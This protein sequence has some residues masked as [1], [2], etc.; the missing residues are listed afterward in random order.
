MTKFNHVKIIDD[1]DEKFLLWVEDEHL[2]CGPRSGEG[3]SW[4]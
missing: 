1:L 3:G 4:R 2:V